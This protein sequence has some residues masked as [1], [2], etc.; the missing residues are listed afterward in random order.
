MTQKTV[1]KLFDY[2]MAEEQDLY[3]QLSG[4]LEALDYVIRTNDARDYLYAYPRSGKRLMVLLTAH[5]DTVHKTP[6]EYVFFD[7]RYNVMW[8]PEGLGADDRAGCYGIM[9]LLGRGLRPTVLFTMGEEK[10]CTGSKAFLQDFPTNQQSYSMIVALDRKGV[11][12]AVFYDNDAQDFHEYVEGWGF[13][14]AHGSH[15]DISKIGPAWKINSVNLSIGYINQHMLSEHLLIDNMMRTLDKVEQ[16]FRSK[17]KRFEYVEKT[18]PVVTT[19]SAVKKTWNRELMRWEDEDG[20]PVYSGTAWDKQSY[21]GYDSYDDYDYGYGRSSYRKE[22]HYGAQADAEADAKAVDDGY[23]QNAIVIVKT[24]DKTDYENLSA[25]ACLWC[26]KKNNDFMDLDTHEGSS[27]NLICKDCFEEQ[28]GYFCVECG[29]PVLAAMEDTD[30]VEQF[31]MQLCN[32]CFE[33]MFASSVDA[34]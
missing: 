25:V 21:G 10:G 1:Q 18:W 27:A 33:G 4:E 14:K 23:K 34:R 30:Y 19:Y 12:D 22:D 15:T 3:E 9:E 20:K 13:T 32:L 8:T 6:P 7:E 11:D 29:Y 17:V 5:M 2:L 24:E 31:N 26:G 28:Q 16:V